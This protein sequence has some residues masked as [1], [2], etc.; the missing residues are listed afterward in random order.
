MF[1]QQLLLITFH[2]LNQI[3]L[4]KTEKGWGGGGE[5]LSVAEKDLD[6]QSKVSLK[7]AEFPRFNTNS[8]ITETK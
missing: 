8:E 3:A 2:T 5:K 4:K 6:F 1:Y 7:T